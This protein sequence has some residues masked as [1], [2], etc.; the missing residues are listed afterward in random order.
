MEVSLLC[1][2]CGL[3]PPPHRRTWGS[4]KLCARRN[5]PATYYC[6]D[7]CMEAHWPKHR[8]WHKAQKERQEKRREGTA[9]DADCSVAEEAA[10]HAEETGDE[11][12]KLGAAA[13]ALMGEEDHHAAAKAWRKI[14]KKWPDQPEAFFNLGVVL[15]RAARRVESAQMYLKA[16]EL[17]ED[18]TKKWADAAASAFETLKLDECDDAP[19]PEWWNDE[20]L[21]ALSARAVALVPDEPGT[22]SMR[23]H[24]LSGGTL[25]KRSWNAGPRTSGEVKEAATWFRR[26]ATLA[27]TPSIKLNCEGRARDCD[28]SADRL[29]AEEEA[30]AA[31]ARAAA[32]AE[33]VEAAEALKVAEAKALAAAEELLAEEEKEKA[34]RNNKASKAKQGKGKKSKGKR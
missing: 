3:A 29:L 16:M 33:A 11:Y 17:H 19:K 30:K 28:V 8:A 12:T 34:E 31:V 14:I 7:A 25:S 15:E 23:A 2:S 18:G 27:F 6:G 10:R 24:V 26:A 13:L 9:A 5:L 22:S 1:V 21:K 32:E 4:C 20:A